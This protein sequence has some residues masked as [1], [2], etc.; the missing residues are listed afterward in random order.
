[1]EVTCFVGMI[2]IYIHTYIKRT[3]LVRAGTFMMH[4]N[5]LTKIYILLEYKMCKKTTRF[6]KKK[7]SEN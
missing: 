5:S 1:M 7:K 2:Y 4:L 3:L 6:I